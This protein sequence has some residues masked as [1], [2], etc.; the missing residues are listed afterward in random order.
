MFR[1]KKIYHD[2]QI[3]K[4]A[5]KG[6]A[7]LDIYSYEN[8]VIPSKNRAAVATGIQIAIPSDCYV[9]IA[10]RSGLAFK[11]GVDTLAGVI[12]SS[13]RGEVKVILQNHGFAE[14]VIYK[15]DRIAQ[16]IFEKIYTDDFVE[17]N[18]LD[19]TDRGEGGFGSTGV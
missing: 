2:A 15:G 17:V 4:R 16:I 11:H 14:F 3:P 1:C 5:D 6:A 18:N 10:P 7:G 8:I 13:Y 19:A 12:D 9:R